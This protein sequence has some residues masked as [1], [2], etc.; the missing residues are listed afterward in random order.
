MPDLI[1]VGPTG[2][3]DTAGHVSVTVGNRRI[4]L[5][6]PLKSVFEPS[7]AKRLTLCDGCLTLRDGCLA[8][9]SGT[10]NL[11]RGQGTRG[12]TG[13]MLHYGFNGSYTT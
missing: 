3:G 1:Y 4:T 11:L 6:G 2:L 8:I 10:R 7:Y 12:A 13:G 5:V 9:R